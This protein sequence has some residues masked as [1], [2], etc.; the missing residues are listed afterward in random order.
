M[1]VPADNAAGVPQRRVAG[2]D[3]RADCEMVYSL[4]EK[5][6]ACWKKV[7][8]CMPRRHDS[9]WF[10]RGLRRPSAEMN[11]VI[12]KRRGTTANLVPPVRE[13]VLGADGFGAPAALMSGETQLP[14]LTGA[15]LD[16]NYAECRYS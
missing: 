14:P 11:V 16:T 6:E 15:I 13:R 5:L 4:V 3:A 1:R 9:I 2:E 7:L 12:H 8:R 10:Y